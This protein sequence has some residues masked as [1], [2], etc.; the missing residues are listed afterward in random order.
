VG[1]HVNVAV[2]AGSVQISEGT[3]VIR[4]S[5]IRHDR[6]KEHGAYARPQGRPGKSKVA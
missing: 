2:V 4:V 1:R 3:K 6:A 5:A